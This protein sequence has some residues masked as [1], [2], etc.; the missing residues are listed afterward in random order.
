MVL[1]EISETLSKVY[2][3]LLQKL[4]RTLGRCEQESG[5]LEN[6]MTA[7]LR[8]YDCQMLNEVSCLKGS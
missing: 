7:L 6:L 3:R 8:V 5:S 1:D 2:A 4:H